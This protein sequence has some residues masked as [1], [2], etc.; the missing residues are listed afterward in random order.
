MIESLSDMSMPASS[1]E[2]R[3]ELAYSPEKL[4]RPAPRALPTTAPGEPPTDPAVK[5]EAAPIAICVAIW[6]ALPAT[7]F[8]VTSKG[9]DRKAVQASPPVAR[10]Q[11]W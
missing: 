6:D 1:M 3:K 10:S 8:E 2:S 5:P 11:R 9:S 4:E 7:M